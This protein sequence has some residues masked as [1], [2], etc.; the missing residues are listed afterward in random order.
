LREKTKA[1]GSFKAY[2]A[3][4]LREFNSIFFYFIY[5]FKKFRAKLVRG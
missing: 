3:R 5:L 1:A 4:L 2:S